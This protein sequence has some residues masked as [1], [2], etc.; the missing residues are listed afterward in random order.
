MSNKKKYVAYRGESKGFKYKEELF[1]N[2]CDNPII[3]KC[4][5]A[6][7]S[8]YVDTASK[9]AVND[10]DAE[11]EKEK[12]KNG[13]IY[14]MQKDNKLEVVDKFIVPNVPPLSLSPLIRKWDNDRETYNRMYGTADHFW[15]EMVV[16]YDDDD[17]D[18]DVDDYD[19][20][21]Q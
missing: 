10:N 5:E 3:S 4:T 12:M 9:E 1:P 20:G 16:P 14:Y 15:E 21:F 8:T 13:W 18:D 11:E 6:A 19:N 2:L 7:E 17:D